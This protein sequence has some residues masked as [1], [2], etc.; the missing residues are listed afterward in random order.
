MQKVRRNSIQKLVLAAALGAALG[1]G[2]SSSV[3]AED[4]TS[5]SYIVDLNSKTVTTLGGFNSLATAINAAGQ[6]AGNSET[7]SG[8][9]HAFITGPNGVGFTDIGTLGGPYIIPYGINDT[10]QVAGY[11]DTASGKT[12]AFITGP[13]GAGMTELGTLGGE[14]VTLLASTAPGGW[15]G[16]PIPL[17]QV[18]I[19]PSSPAPTAWA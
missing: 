10:G 1:P 4:T 11:F 8:A 6:V 7:A 15:L 9:I 14:I 17:L 2:F 3:F 16:T 5:R 19:M 12:N 18:P 13:N